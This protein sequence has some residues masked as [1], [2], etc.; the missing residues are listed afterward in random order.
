MARYAYRGTDDRGRESRGV[1]DCESLTEAAAEL[2]RRGVSTLVLERDD[3]EEISTPLG[4]V[5]AFSYFNRSL[6]NLSRAGIPLP[7]AVREVGRGIRRGLLKRG[8][9]SIEAALEEGRT[10]DEALKESGTRFPAYYE[11]MVRAGISSGSLP[12]VLHS[13]ARTHEG[14]RRARRAVVGALAYPVA[15]LCLGAA[16]LGVSMVFFVPLYEGFYRTHGVEPSLLPSLM[17]RLSHSRVFLVVV[18]V[19]LVW[20]AWGI[21]VWLLRTASGQRLLFRIPFIGRTARS[22]VQARLLGVL[23]VLLAAKVTLEE[24]LPLAVGGSASA[25]LSRDAEQWGAR[26]REGSRLVEILSDSPV[27]TS[28][29]AAYLHLAEESGRLAEAAGEM[30]EILSEQVAASSDMLFVVLFPLAMLITGLLLG[31][32]IVLFSS[33]YIDLVQQIPK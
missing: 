7:R 3:W 23:S 20:L 4:E 33:S 21:V 11:A 31:P 14:V 2:R 30:G 9:Q 15:V 26:A 5:D 1:I 24:A 19:A 18:L 32:P 16:V 12:R 29:I 22:L 28:G 27:V 8:I 6:A 10:L 25:L 17:F 13:V